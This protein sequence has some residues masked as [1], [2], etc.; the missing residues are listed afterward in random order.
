MYSSSTVDIQT[1][2]HRQCLKYN[3]Y[4]EDLQINVNTSGLYSFLINSSVVR[5]G[6]IYKDQFNP[7]NTSDNLYSNFFYQ[8]FHGDAFGLAANLQ[9]NV[10]Y[11]LILTKYNRYGIGTFSVIASGPEKVIFNRICKCLYISVISRKMFSF[12]IHKKFHNY[13]TLN[14]FRKILIKELNHNTS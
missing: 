9:F 12:L 2:V 3:Y 5:Y 14:I 10:T 13:E 6:F 4:Y 1:Y 7:F 11:F 8:C